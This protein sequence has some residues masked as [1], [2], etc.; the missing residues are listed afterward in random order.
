[1]IHPLLPRKT[2]FQQLWMD[3]QFWNF[4]AFCFYFVRSMPTA[5]TNSVEWVILL[6]SE[7][8]FSYM[9]D[10]LNFRQLFVCP[11][12]KGLLTVQK[13][14][15]NSGKF[16]KIWLTALPPT[17]PGVKKCIFFT[18]AIII[19][20]FHSQKLISLIYF[21]RNIFIKKKLIF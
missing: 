15:T 10:N 21:Q 17:P 8:F 2:I 19:S 3:C 14:A 5:S 20:N 1:M 16:N 7:R 6:M 13:R 9:I 4:S 12:K 18:S 11:L